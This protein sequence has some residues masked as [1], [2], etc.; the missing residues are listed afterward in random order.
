MPALPAGPKTIRAFEAPMSLVSS[1]T[2][3]SRTPKRSVLIR[4]NSE[5]AACEVVSP[6]FLG[7]EGRVPRLADE[8]AAFAK[9]FMEVPGG[10]TVCSDPS[11]YVW[12]D[13]VSTIFSSSSLVFP[14]DRRFAAVSITPRSAFTP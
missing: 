3:S 10:V 1:P 12:W 13:E 9:V 14:S 6:L 8:L 7:R 4:T 2:S 5:R 11:K